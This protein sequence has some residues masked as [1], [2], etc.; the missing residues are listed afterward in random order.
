VFLLGRARLQRPALE[1]WE[2]GEGPA[3]ES[4]RL[5][6]RIRHEVT[7]PIGPAVISPQE[8]TPPPYARA[9]MGAN[10]T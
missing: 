2:H 4:P 7:L 8:Q 10:Q 3:W 9:R 6:A 1:Q 5:A